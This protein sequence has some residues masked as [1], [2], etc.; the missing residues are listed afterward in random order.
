MGVCSGVNKLRVDAHFPA[1]ALH[2]ALEKMRDTELFAD[3][4]QVAGNVRFVLHHACATDH[5]QIGDFREVRQDFVLH[6]IGEISVLFIAT[7]IFEWQ[8]RDAFLHDRRR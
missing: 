6:A 3:F 8:H 5:F 2:A 1:G 4:A 7:K